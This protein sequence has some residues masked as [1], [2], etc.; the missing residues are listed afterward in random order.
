MAG[1]WDGLWMV[2][3]KDGW[4]AAI[5]L[6]FACDGLSDAC[7]A[8]D[9]KTTALRLFNARRLAAFFIDS[10]SA[11]ALR[12]VSL[13]L[14]RFAA[15]RAAFLALVLAAG[16]AFGRGFA[17]RLAFFGHLVG[18]GRHQLEAGKCHCKHGEFKQFHDVS[19]I[20]CRSGLPE[21]TSFAAG[22]AHGGWRN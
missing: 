5:V 3:S 18:R 14:L 12:R 11:F 19:F 8:C 10:A 6:P 15:V 20:R 17:A 21:E 1:L 13:F 16:I 7:A 22:G 2:R 9:H 4:P